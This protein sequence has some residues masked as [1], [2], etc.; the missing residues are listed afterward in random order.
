MFA[1]LQARHW[2]GDQSA[3]LQGGELSQWDDLQGHCDCHGD[4]GPGGGHL[5]LL[6]DGEEDVSEKGV[7]L[8]G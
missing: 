4:V 6:E 7:C 1:L 2:A 8:Q 5:L 3:D